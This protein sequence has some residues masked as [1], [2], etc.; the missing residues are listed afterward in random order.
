VI[1]FATH[2]FLDSE[3]PELSGLVLSLLDGQGHPRDGFLR[4]RDVYN[5]DL[6][7]DLVVL[8]GC[9]TALGKDVRGEGLLGLT[10]GFLYAGASRVMASLWP[11]RDRATPEL[12]RRFYHA[13]LHD[14]LP[15]A[16]ALRAA[17]LS[18]RREPRWRDP[19]SWA[20]FVVQGD[21][22]AATP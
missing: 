6:S 1:H 17:Q 9:R 21:W 10:R 16:A 15:P 2:G 12:M 13:L 4:L 20:P 18:L 5:L 19:Y 7:A 14:R 8:S 3:A 22:Q 11:V